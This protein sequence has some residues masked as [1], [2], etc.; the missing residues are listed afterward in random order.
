MV[1]MFLLK[2]TES[3]LKVWAILKIQ[4][5]FNNIK[6]SDENYRELSLNF[7]IQCKNNAL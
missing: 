6:F 2:Q 5:F 3:I 4:F 1:N 7:S